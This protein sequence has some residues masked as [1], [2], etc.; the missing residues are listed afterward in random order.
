M[1]KRRL[2]EHKFKTYPAPHLEVAYQNEELQQ[3]CYHIV[4]AFY[5]QKHQFIHDEQDA[6]LRVILPSFVQ[7]LLQKS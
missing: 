3:F 4:D 6:A 2:S 7:T 1:R 5:D